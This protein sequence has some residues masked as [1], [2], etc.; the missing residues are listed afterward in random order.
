MKKLFAVLI[1]LL[2]IAGVF[3]QAPAKMSYQAVIRNSSNELVSNHNI[4]MRVNI[5]QGSVTGKEVYT[6]IITPTPSTNDNGLVSVAIGGGIGFSDIDWASGPYFIK[7]ETDPAGG[8]NY[9]ITSISQLLSVPYAQYA[10]KAGNGFSGNYNDLTGSPVLATIATSGSYNDL[11]DKPVL[12]SGDYQSLIHKPNIADSVKVYGFDGDYNGLVNKPI[13]FD[14]KYSS[15]TDTPTLATIARS[16]SYNDLVNKPTIPVAADGSETK[17]TSGTNIA[18][19]GIGTTNNPYIINANGGGIFT[20][21]IGEL[22]GGGIV[23]AV[24]KES[25]TE[26]GLIVSLQDLSTNSIWS[27]VT[28][29]AIGTSAQSYYDG[30]SNTDAIISQPGHLSSAAKLCKD[31][32]G[33]GYNDWYLPS[34]WELN[35]CY[36]V[37][38][39]INRIVGDTNG[40]QVSFNFVYWSSTESG[41]SSAW[42][43]N[44]WV[45]HPTGATVKSDP[46]RV[47]AVRKF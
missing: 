46:Y 21:Y 18:V 43:H 15:L 2:A 8:D 42:N 32:K 25:G 7:I 44:F 10:E 13:L 37:A 38:M 29:T 45:G 41:D 31:F 39:I 24:W 5:I 3:A 36:N 12:F 14:G 17:L 40:F 35:A 20:H 1:A 6:E 11:S 22:Y 4:G 47:R 19:S 34:V 9:T 28:Y 33:G 16:G 30:K 23:V 26:H 27:N